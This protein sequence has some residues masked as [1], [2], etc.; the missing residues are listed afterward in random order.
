MERLNNNKVISRQARKIKFLFFERSASRRTESR[1]KNGGQSLIEVL[2]AIGIFM[3]V[4]GAITTVLYGGQSAVVDAEN[5][6]TASEFAIEGREAVRSIKTRDWNELTDGSHGLIFSDQWFFTD[7]SDSKDIF[8]RVIEIATVD[9]NTKIATT[10]VT[11]TTEG[12][13][14]KSMVV[15]KIARWDN[16]AQGVCKIG[17]LSGNWANPQTLGSADLGAGVSGTDVVVKL[18]YVFVSGV[19]STAAKHDVFVFDVT[20]P[21]MPQKIASLDIGSGGINTLFLKGNYLYAASPNDS[22]ELMIFDI[23]VPASI[24]LVGSYNLDGGADGLSV[25]AFENTVAVGRARAATYELAF[26]NAT[27]PVSIQM[28]AE[29]ATDGDIHDFAASGEKLYLVSEQSDPD[30]WVYDISNSL[31]PTFVTNYDIP[32]ITED[33]SIFVQEGQAGAPVSNILVGNEQDE[34]LVIGATT[35]LASGW[36]VR[37]RLGV[38]GQV[39]DIVCVENNLAFLATSN[40][41]KEF[42]IVNIANPDN[43][44]E[45]AS[46]NFPQMGTGIDFADNKVFMS[47]R[48][49]D[50]LRIITSGP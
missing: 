32:G 30:V 31:S 1:S 44:V 26:L 19:S 37:D 5:A 4:V 17:P 7:S 11:W 41:N 50:A 36:Y 43:I 27:N 35:T 29:Y 39:F 16:P 12:R 21:N 18:P 45:Y 34:L 10:T 2:V 38:S 23:S 22:K 14:Q 6:N 25:Y 15:E 47:V 8:T 24:N 49:N 40:S 20:N 46:L 13:T 42:I 9:S 33:I 3:T 28:V 48:S